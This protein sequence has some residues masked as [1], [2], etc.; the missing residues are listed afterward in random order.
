MSIL[1]NM[2]V[3]GLLSFDSAAITA[4]VHKNRAI[5]FSDGIRLSPAELATKQQQALDGS[6]AAAKLVVRHYIVGSAD[7]NGAEPWKRLL[8]SRGDESEMLS[9]ASQLAEIRGRSGCREALFWLRVA[10]SSRSQ[11][12]RRSASAMRERLRLRECRPTG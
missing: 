12:I 4:A 8:A 5:D 2:V 10:A 6:D 7:F 1:R 3:F 11:K 9:L